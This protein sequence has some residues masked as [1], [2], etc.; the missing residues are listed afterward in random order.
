MFSIFSSHGRMLTEERKK[1]LQLQ[2]EIQQ[3]EQVLQSKEVEA[4]ASAAEA[5]KL[6]G[7]LLLS[8][9]L[10]EHF[11]YFGDSLIAL[12]QTLQSLSSLLLAEKQTA[13]D[14]SN[15][16][17]L[18]SEGTALLVENLGIV[19]NTVEEAV[20]NVESLN[21]R[22]D[23]IDAVVTLINGVS[24]QTNLLALNAA[25]EAA[26]AGEHGRGFAVVADEVRSLSG[27]TSSA[28]EEI[29][30]E[31]KMIQT[32]AQ[33]TASKMKQMA[34][35]SSHLSEVGHKA[36][37]G[38]HKLLE[39]SRKM[40][41]TI[42]VSALRGFVELAKTDHLVFKFAIYQ[43]LMGHSKAT[44]EGLADHTSC[45]LGK[46]YFEGDGRDCFSHLPGYREMDEPHKNVH[47]QGRFA[48]EKYTQGNYAEAL[49]HI[50]LMEDASMEV[51][52]LLEK[53]AR[54]GESDSNLLCASH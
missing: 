37:D 51:L 9:G 12:Q 50:K 10:F 23:A 45:R 40:E 16:S 49:A 29:S 3:L 24:Q 35:E 21:Q 42:S 38:I 17:V 4:S 22:V 43:I 8:N 54:A 20:G 13:I 18:A 19:R 15:E 32:G 6:R 36:G 46:W 53:M 14:A 41:R 47:E 48:I 26:R 7:Q 44:T 52:D 39:L 11:V 33:E 28:T 34:E 25:I 1:S 2:S 31:V 27:R 30:S 5:D